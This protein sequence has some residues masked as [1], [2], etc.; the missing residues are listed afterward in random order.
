[1]LLEIMKEFYKI[2]YFWVSEVF[3]LIELGGI[4]KIGKD[5]INGIYC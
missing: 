1:M 3:Y 4:W 5:L 2:V